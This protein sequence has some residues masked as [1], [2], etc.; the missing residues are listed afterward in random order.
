MPLSRSSAGLASGPGCGAG[1]AG[2]GSG[3][4]VPSVPLTSTFRPGGI[5]VI[6]SVTLVTQ[7][8]PSSRARMAVWDSV[9]PVAAT[10]A[11]G[12]ATRADT[13]PAVRAGHTTM[14]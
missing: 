10:M 8:I 2:S 11:A 7:G 13:V 6:A 4:M 12:R 5:E 14:A 3:R 9:P 1:P